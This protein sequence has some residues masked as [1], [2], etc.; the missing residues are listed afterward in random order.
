[1]SSHPLGTRQRRAGLI[2]GS[3]VTPIRSGTARGLVV[4]IEG[5]S[6]VNM[7]D[8]VEMELVSREAARGWAMVL[9]EAVR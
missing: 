5:V 2:R 4:S 8:G 9:G 3:G 7:G 1:M 6:D